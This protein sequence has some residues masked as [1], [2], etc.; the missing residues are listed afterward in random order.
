MAVAARCRAA[1]FM[2]GD[3]GFFCS[4]VSASSAH[5]YG[6]CCTLLRT[7]LSR[8]ISTLYLIDL[9]EQLFLKQG[10]TTVSK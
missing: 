9:L 10:E 6:C 7:A 5:V 3:L 8:N 2:G 1:I 4:L